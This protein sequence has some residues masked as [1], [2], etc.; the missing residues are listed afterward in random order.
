[1]VAYPPHVCIIQIIAGIM[2]TVNPEIYI[3]AAGASS[4]TQN[5]KMLWRLMSL[6]G[7]VSC[8]RRHACRLACR[9]AS[10][11]VSCKARAADPGICIHNLATWRCWLPRVH[12]HA[13]FQQY[14]R[15]PAAGKAPKYP[16]HIQS[17]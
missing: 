4:A 15:P 14:S 3:S 13:C 5:P 17:I 10:T 8:G 16:K 6:I 12:R 9:T 11:R 2:I 7:Q 1:M